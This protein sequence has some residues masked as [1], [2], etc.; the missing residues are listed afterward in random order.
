[1]NDPDAA[2]LRSELDGIKKK[3]AAEGLGSIDEAVTKLQTTQASLVQAEEARDKFLDELKEAK[4]A[5]GS[6]GGELGFLKQRVEELEEAAKNASHTEPTPPVKPKEDPPSKTV[7]EELAE[8]EASLTDVQKQ[9]FQSIYEAETDDDKADKL[10]K[11]KPYRLA[12]VKGLKG[13][14]ELRTRPK[15]VFGDKVKKEIPSVDGDDPYIA[16]KKRV[17]GFAV[18]PAGGGGVSSRGGKP[19]ERRIHPS[20]VGQ[21]N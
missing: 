12:I 6:K 10:M 17:K 9:A 7:D 8:V 4:K 21:Y 15:S 11:D 3:L 2:V 20:L 16:L 5:L 14:K 1:M 18:G 13:D 19:R